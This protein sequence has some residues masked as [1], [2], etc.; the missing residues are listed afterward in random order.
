MKDYVSHALISLGTH[1][2]NP[3]QQA[4]GAPTIALDILDIGSVVRNQGGATRLI[5]IPD[6]NWNIRFSC[7]L[8][9]STLDQIAVDIT[10]LDNPG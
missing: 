5:H 7:N 9:R 2:R 1:L 10:T 6:Y 4:R 8:N 3:Q